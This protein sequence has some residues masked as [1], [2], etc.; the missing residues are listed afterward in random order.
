MYL[1][2]RGLKEGRRITTQVL[3]FSKNVEE[4]DMEL[5][6]I[7]KYGDWITNTSFHHLGTLNSSMYKISSK[8]LCDK[9]KSHYTKL[10]ENKTA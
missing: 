1:S 8:E 7:G 3:F 4:G 2:T 10:S 6:S 5:K 9:S